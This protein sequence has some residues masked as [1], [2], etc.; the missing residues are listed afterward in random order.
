MCRVWASCSLD[1]ARSSDRVN[2]PV[3]KT[4]QATRVCTRK[5][6]G[7]RRHIIQ[8]SFL[9]FSVVSPSISRII[10][11]V[12]L[13]DRPQTLRGYRRCRGGSLIRG[14]RE[15]RRR[16]CHTFSRLEPFSVRVTL[17]HARTST[18]PSFRVV[19]RVVSRPSETANSSP[20]RQ[21]ARG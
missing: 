5:R 10:E 3:L 6:R 16:A 8:T 7:H 19:S 4:E 2:L 14:E 12:S 21:A 9:S 1:I 17:F 18:A 13:V 15:S 20:I 11:C